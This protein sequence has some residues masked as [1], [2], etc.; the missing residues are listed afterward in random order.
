MFNAE[1]GKVALLT[2]TQ[3]TER[4]Q[5]EVTIKVNQEYAESSSARIPWRKW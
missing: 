1:I 3:T 5:V 2:I 4:P